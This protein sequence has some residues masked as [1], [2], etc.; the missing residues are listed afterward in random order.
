MCIFVSFVPVLGGKLQPFRASLC[1]AVQRRKPL[2]SPRFADPKAYV[3]PRVFLSG[4][5]SIPLA[6]VSL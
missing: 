4:G 3:F 5:E 6:P 2:P 1:P